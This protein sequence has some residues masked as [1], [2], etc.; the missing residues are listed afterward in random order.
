MEDALEFLEDYDLDEARV[1]LLMKLG[2][3]T[4]AAVIHAKNGSILKAV[5]AL[6]GSVHGV[7]HVRP[8]ID[9]G[10]SS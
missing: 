5:E 3:A 2:R 1:K 6:A 8:M 9:I 4:K 10:K 7:D